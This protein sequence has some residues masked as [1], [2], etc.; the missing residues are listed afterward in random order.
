MYYIMMNLQLLE[1]KMTLPYSYVLAILCLWVRNLCGVRQR[2]NSNK[3]IE[4]N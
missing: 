1:Y 4:C 2:N 3:C